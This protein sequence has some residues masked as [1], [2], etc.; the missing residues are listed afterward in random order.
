MI[1]AQIYLQLIYFLYCRCGSQAPIG[2]R[3]GFRPH[4]R[5]Q[6]RSLRLYTNVICHLQKVAVATSDYEDAGN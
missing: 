5:L 6:L 1:Q 4:L 3:R 2:E